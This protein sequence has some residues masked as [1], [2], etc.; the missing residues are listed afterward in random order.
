MIGSTGALGGSDGRETERVDV[1]PVTANFF[2]L[3]GVDPMLGRH[4]LPTEEKSG[5][6]QVAIL[7]Y[8]LWKRR[9][10]GDRSIVGRRIMLDGVENE[11]VGVM[12]DTFSL[13]LPAEA[14]LVTDARYG[15]RCVST[16]R[17]RRRGTSRCSPCSAA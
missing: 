10:G 4:F 11:V 14:F 13:L 3:L 2:S 7:S 9:Y 8:N 12:P 6:P 1:T 16:T 17:R 5:S 15:S